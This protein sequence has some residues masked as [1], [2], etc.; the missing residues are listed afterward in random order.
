MRGPSVANTIGFAFATFAACMAMRPIV[1]NSFFTHVATGRLMVDTGRI[2]SIDPY[3]FTA[4]GE[5]WVVQSWLVSGVYGVVESWA[6]GAGL[7]L[8]SGLVVGLLVWLVWLLT[9]P[10]R[11]L[12]SR[13]II[14]GLVLVV[15]LTFWVPRPLLFGLL[16]FVMTMTLIERAW[17]PRWMVPIMWCWANAH[18]SFPLGLVAI[19]AFAIGRRLDKQDATTETRAL[20]WALAG[21]AVAA[22]NPIGPKLLIF[23]INVLGRTEVLQRV[24]E[25]QSPNFSQNYARL[26]LLQVALAIALLVRRPSYRAVVPLVVFV[27]AALLGLR[28]IPLASL[29]LIPGLVAGLGGIGSL[30]GRERGP[31]PTVLFAVVVVLGL[32]GSSTLLSQPTYDLATY[33]VAGVGW[34]HD[35]NLVGSGARVATSDVNG[36][37]LELLY[38]PSHQGFFDDRYDMFPLPF[39]RDYLALDSGQ[40]GW[41]DI[42][43]RQDIDVVMWSRAAALSSVMQES[44][45]FR[46]MYQDDAVVIA[47][48]RGSP[49]VAC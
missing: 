36:N 3:T 13:V 43:R 40:T 24:I 20:L 32:A 15:G 34:L 17:D 48:R 23:P 28:N 7:R 47:C 31:A 11:T 25:W 45:T 41:N 22:I 29:V 30:E 5:P 2:P 21:T 26:F 4:N 39:M 37:F 10:A 27:A 49:R 42:L 16:F 19:G 44:S 12:A 9:A 6:G 18:G 35:H 1:D 38:G 46:V 8:L 14:T 33:P